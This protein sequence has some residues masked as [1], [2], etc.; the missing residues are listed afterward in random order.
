MVL[1]VPTCRD[2]G[3]VLDVMSLLLDYASKSSGASSRGAPAQFL[4]KRNP[5]RWIG[6][7]RRKRPVRSSSTSEGGSQSPVLPWARLAYDACLNSGST[8]GCS[9]FGAG[10][11]SF[12]PH[13]SKD[14]VSHTLGSSTKYR[15]K[16]RLRCREK[17][18]LQASVGGLSP[19]PLPASSRGFCWRTLLNRA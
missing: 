11:I 6:T 15:P 2:T 12:R 10:T 1:A 5:S 14:T 13:F 3:D 18:V 19:P 8:A 4:H 17:P 7:W 16:T 9:E